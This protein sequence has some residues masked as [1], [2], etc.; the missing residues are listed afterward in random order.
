MAIPSTVPLNNHLGNTTE[1]IDVSIDIEDFPFIAE[2][3][4]AL[5]A[6]AK[7]AVEREYATNAWDSHVEAGVFRPI[8]I[9]LPT[10]FS[11]FFVVQD[12]GLG[13]NVE[14]IRRTYTKYGRSTKRDN[15]DV[16]GQLGMG[17]KS[18]LAYAP[19]FNIDAVKDGQIINAIFTKNEVGLG[20][21]KVMHTGPTD[22][23][24]G[25][26]ISIPVE[27][28]DI[29]SFIAEAKELFS[30]WAPGT[31]LVDGKA[32]ERPAWE[33]NC[34]WL[35][36]ERLTALVRHDDLDS[37][38][39][40]M[41]N[42]PYPTEDLNYRNKAGNYI[43]HRFVAVVNIGDVEFVP[44]REA[45]KTTEFTKGTIAALHEYI[46]VSYDRAF[47]RALATCE[48][49][50]DEMKLRVAWK[51]GSSKRLQARG[52]AAIWSYDPHAGHGRRA[53][54]KHDSYNFQSLM[55]DRIVIT[56]FPALTVSPDARTRIRNFAPTNG[57]YVICCTGVQGT[58]SL[59]GR[60][61]V[62]KYADVLAATDP[63]NRGRQSGG[64]R[65]PKVET[66]YTVYG[67]NT[68]SSLT[69]AEIAKVAEDPNMTVIYM[70]PGNQR[71]LVSNLLDGKTLVVGLYS[72]S[73]L[74]RI[75]R[76]VPGIRSLF[77]EAQDRRERIAAAVTEADRQ[78]Y[79][80]HRHLPAVL[81]N[82][83]PR[84]VDDPDLRRYITL[85][86]S[87]Y[88]LTLQAAVDYG[89]TIGAPQQP[90][91]TGDSLLE[92]YTLLGRMYSYADAE[93]IL[94]YLNGKFPAITARRHAEAAERFA[95]ATQAALAAV[96]LPEQVAA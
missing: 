3:L 20:V 76:F 86:T 73:Q 8:E 96:T 22:E 58:G 41:G 32:P 64:N 85:A 34:L 21:V 71:H 25:V 38:Y 57:T 55:N 19:Q 17:S 50:W 1:D 77:S 37:S 81:K 75:E 26:R 59:D 78:Q 69:A 10:P 2:Q 9:T 33:D 46:K 4:N 56:G 16:A 52:A 23:P 83:D 24:N 82:V 93:D 47:N 42:V 62:I 70:P 51:D 44:S 13:M 63:I 18:G 61:N 5:Y 94:I 45:L 48:T 91:V 14:D 43:R 80:A 30:F 31:V 88:S 95:K 53:A 35:D 49:P 67:S 79:Q 65:G 11:P 29:N 89:M 39:I 36:T 15:N 90:T 12:F 68:H 84:L 72:S 74:P 7:R 6:N 40:V 66:R 28:Q 92:D 87:D 54:S 60:A 27:S